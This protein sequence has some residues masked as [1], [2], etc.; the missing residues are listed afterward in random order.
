[1]PARASSGLTRA[2]RRGGDWLLKAEFNGVGGSQAHIM[3]CAGASPAHK[4]PPETKA[5]SAPP[6]GAVSFAS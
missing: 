1:M 3:N 2:A 4:S 5:A 6:A